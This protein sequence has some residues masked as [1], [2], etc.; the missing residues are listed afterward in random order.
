MAGAM[1]RIPRYGSPGADE[2]SG[3][4][5]NIVT[6]LGRVVQHEKEPSTPFQESSKQNTP[7]HAR[8]TDV[9]KRAVQVFPLPLSL[10]HPSFIG[11]CQSNPCGTACH[12][13]REKSVDPAE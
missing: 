3:K 1:N 13:C 12:G 5:S 6:F 2:N 11:W 7:E 10:F 4:H 9:A 8:M